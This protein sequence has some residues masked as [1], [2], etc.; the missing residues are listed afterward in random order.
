MPSK[1]TISEKT[2]CLA[3]VARAKT[4]TDFAL[5]A[6]LSKLR[7][8]IADLIKKTKGGTIPAPRCMLLRYDFFLKRGRF[9]EPQPLPKGIRRGRPKECYFNSLK[10]ALLQDDLTYCE[11]FVVIP[12]SKSRMT[13]VEHGW[14]VTK[15]GT[16]IDVTLE[17][18]GLAYFGVPYTAKERGG[19]QSSLPRIDAILAKQLET[20]LKERK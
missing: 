20:D 5:F 6:H 7:K 18:P 9:F 4:D 19:F 12:L 10:L 11:G 1:P 3:Q 2:R 16:V 15:S 8:Q 13:D 17:K 14:C